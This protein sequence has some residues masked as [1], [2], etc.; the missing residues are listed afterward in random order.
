[1]LKY[2]EE[3]E[4]KER[5]KR[6]FKATPTSEKIEHQDDEIRILDHLTYFEYAV[7]KA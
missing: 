3:L 5:M 2:V 1:M 6:K 7:E 4:E